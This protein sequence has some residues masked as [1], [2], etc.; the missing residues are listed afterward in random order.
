MREWEGGGGGGGKKEKG[1]GNNYFFQGEG[2][3]GGGVF[4]HIGNIELHT[5]VFLWY[6][7]TYYRDEQIF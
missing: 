2:G 5:N 7:F 3:G 4:P 1:K 6:V